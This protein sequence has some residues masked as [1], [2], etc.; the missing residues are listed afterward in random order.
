M[1]APRSAPLLVRANRKA[2]P[3]QPELL[4]LVRGSLVAAGAARAEYGV[5][6]CD[7]TRDQNSRIHQ[8]PWVCGGRLRG[9]RWSVASGDALDP[10]ATRAES[11]ATGCR[12]CRARHE[13]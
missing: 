7:R 10:V 1:T 11:A 9:R 4:V 13:H 8:S 3:V 2:Y 6:P 5:G 12:C